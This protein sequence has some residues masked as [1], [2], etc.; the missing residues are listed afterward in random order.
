MLGLAAR[1]GW[2]SCSVPRSNKQQVWNFF[3][4]MHKHMEHLHTSP[5]YVYTGHATQN[6]FYFTGKPEV[7]FPGFPGFPGAYLSNVGTELL[8]SLKQ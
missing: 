4:G 2:G 8:S 6:F 1:G 7:V 3:P 5:T